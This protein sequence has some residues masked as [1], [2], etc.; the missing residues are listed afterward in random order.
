VAVELNEEEVAEI[1][2][3]H[4]E[5]QFPKICEKCGRRYVSL[6]DY[7]QRTV[8]VGAPISF[9]AAE[10]DW[11]PRRPVGTLS[12]ANCACGTTLS[13]GSEGMSL[14]TVWRLMGW[15]RRET[16]RRGVTLET[17]LSALRE[18]IDREV[19]AAAS[20]VHTEPERLEWRQALARV[21]LEGTVVAM[22]SV[23]VV[24]VA[25][26]PVPRFGPP[27]GMFAC[28]WS[29]LLLARLTVPPRFLPSAVPALLL[30]GALAML[31]SVGLAPGV[32]LV[33]L[34]AAGLATVTRGR[35]AGALFVAAS[36]AAVLGF[37]ALA[38]ERA[39]PVP[40]ARL[41]DASLFSNWIRVDGVLLLTGVLAVV[42]L[43]ELVRRLESAWLE[44]RA[45]AA[46][47]REAN[48]ER[49]RAEE[50]QRR[51][52][53]SAR[54]AEHL[55]AIGRLAE[56][57]A[58][59]FNNQLLVILSWTDLLADAPEDERREG[60]AEIRTAASHASQLTRRLLAFAKKDTYQPRVL[61]LDAA[62]ASL[63]GSLRRVLR[64]DI[65]VDHRRT[66]VPPVLLDEAALGHVLLNLAVNAGD[67]MPDGGS[68]ILSTRLLSSDELP[69]DVPDPA[70]SYV[71][72][73]VQD[74]GEGMDAATR[75]R[76]FEPFF[77]TKAPGKG[78]GLG[79]AGVYGI[80]VQAGGFIQ[81]E[82]EPGRGSAFTLA[83]P[84]CDQAKKTPSVAPLGQRSVGRSVLLV[85]LEESVRRAMATALRTAGLRVVEA[86]DVEQ[87]LVA[88]RRHRGEI[89]L[90]CTDAVLPGEGVQR[91]ID[92]VMELY[93]RAMVLVCSGHGDDLLR[94]RGMGSASVELLRKPFSGDQLVARIDA[95]I[96]D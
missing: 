19:L 38:A 18:R 93:P 26:R 64:S 35:R 45:A 20:V 94:A 69:E 15:A 91:L 54:S 2:R 11:R 25:V 79:L 32:W 80:V 44:Q 30:A 71:A 22:L 70:A 60:L 9:D 84:R 61:D 59:D 47:E 62:V 57:V 66:A 89:D 16:K 7:L 83:F 96:G 68:L 58:H 67:A 39:I 31:P 55:E 88:A 48:Q 40:P 65:H 36:C 33:L 24:W 49:A 81:V 5:R 34:S 72:L 8:H 27:V 82:S 50:E 78:T 41:T 43:G 85:E 42:T 86:A 3:R 13:L 29:I 95:L 63:A 10:G 21:Y 52:E 90:L 37:G 92:G 6:K 28:V 87:G 14:L 73:R 23:A 74:S 17:L 1:T 56:G 77:T 4:L 76:I 53:A 46:R 12:M 51:A 75:A